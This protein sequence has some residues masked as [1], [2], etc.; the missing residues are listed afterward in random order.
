MRRPFGAFVVQTVWILQKLLTPSR[1]L[2]TVR[3]F[4]EY[5]EL[6]VKKRLCERSLAFATLDTRD[7]PQD[8]AGL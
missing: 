5:P 3:R 4:R 2:D 6:A 1:H 8:L 7:V